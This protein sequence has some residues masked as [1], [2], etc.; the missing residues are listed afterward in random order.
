ML[1][2]V[3]LFYLAVIAILFV[4]P[5][6][7]GLSPTRIMGRL[8]KRGN[9]LNGIFVIMMLCPATLLGLRNVHAR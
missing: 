1:I 7:Y 3:N 9:L 2:E 4:T 5:P 8:A 6:V